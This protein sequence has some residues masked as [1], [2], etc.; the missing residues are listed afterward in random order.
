MRLMRKNL[1]IPFGIPSPKPILEIGAFL[2]RTETELLL[3][4]RN[5]IPERL[6]RAGF[7]FEFS[8]LNQALKELL[9]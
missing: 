1:N 4:N 8:K 9:Q 3:K 5:V 7:E 6:Q 2:I